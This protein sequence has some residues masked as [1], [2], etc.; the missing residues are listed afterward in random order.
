MQFNEMERPTRIAVQR[1]GALYHVGPAVYPACSGCV[2]AVVN[3]SLPQTDQKKT[4]G[5][6]REGPS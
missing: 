6:G 2:V 3:F 4:F 1:H 5:A